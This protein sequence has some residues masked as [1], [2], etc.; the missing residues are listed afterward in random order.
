MDMWPV[1]AYW[2][3]SNGLK[4]WKAWVAILHIYVCIYRFISGGGQQGNL[5]KWRFYIQFK[6]CFL[7]IVSYLVTKSQDE[8]M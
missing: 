7:L 6:S 4:K 2:Q 5:T 1:Y 8:K 3:K